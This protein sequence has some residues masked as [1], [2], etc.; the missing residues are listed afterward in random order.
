MSLC[1]WSPTFLFKELKRLLT[2]PIKLPH[3]EQNMWC[4]ATLLR[5]ACISPEKK[6][7]DNLPFISNRTTSSAPSSRMEA[8]LWE[9]TLYSSNSLCS[10]DQ[11]LG[12]VKNESR[13]EV[14]SVWEAQRILALTF[15]PSCPPFLVPPSSFSFSP[16]FS[17]S[18]FL[19]L[20]FPLFSPLPHFLND[21]HSLVFTFLLPFSSSPAKFEDCL[22]CSGI[23]KYNV[24]LNEQMVFRGEKNY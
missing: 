8:D 16:S 21:E 17:S 1:P 19:L 10:K 18:A 2:F 15:P 5:E 6:E 22:G 11:A 12:L 24:D 13:V 23:G 9:S 3:C 4:G 14:L 20:L 7:E